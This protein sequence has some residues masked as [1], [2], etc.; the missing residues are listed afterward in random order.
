MEESKT[1]RCLAKSYAEIIC[2]KT[3]AISI[4]PTKYYWK[5]LTI[6][7][8]NMSNEEKKPRVVWNFNFLTMLAGFMFRYIYT[9]F[10]K[11]PSPMLP[12]NTFTILSID[13]LSSLRDLCL[14]NSLP[15]VQTLAGPN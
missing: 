7:T 12:V 15:N 9:I 10:I 1:I 2:V 14:L 5:Q 13:L 8:T 11:R 4:M 6:F 3:D